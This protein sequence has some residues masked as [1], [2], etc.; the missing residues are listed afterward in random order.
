LNDLYVSDGN[1]FFD[2]YQLPG[3]NGLSFWQYAWDKAI[4]PTSTDIGI[5]VTLLQ[6][7]RD[8]RVDGN[9]TIPAAQVLAI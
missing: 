2:I 6:H 3:S 7:C 8:F 5:F 4:G 1:L 9:A